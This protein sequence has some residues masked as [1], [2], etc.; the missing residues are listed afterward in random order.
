MKI[1]A[2]DLAPHFERCREV[3]DARNAGILGDRQAESLGISMNREGNVR[4][5]WQDINESDIYIFKAFLDFYTDT[6]NAVDNPKPTNYV[7][8]PI[9]GDAT[10]NKIV[11][12]GT[13]RNAFTIVRPMADDKYMLIQE[14]RLGY[15]ES[16]VSGTDV[17]YDEAR[18]ETEDQFHGDSNSYDGRKFVTVVWKGVSPDKSHSISESIDNLSPDLDDFTVNGNS[19][20]GYRRVMVR[21]QEE[22]DGSHSIRMMVAQ[23]RLTYDMY[24]NY[25]TENQGAVVVHFGVPSDLVQAILDG[26][27]SIGKSARVSPPDNMG[28]HTI[29]VTTSSP[30]KNV[31][32]NVLIS[33][34]CSQEVY[35]SAYYGLTLAEADSVTI[36]ANENGVTYRL[37]R[38]PRGDGFWT[39]I[40]ETITTKYQDTTLYTS[41]DS[42]GRLVKRRSQLGVTNEEVEEIAQATGWTKQQTI[43]LNDDCSKDVDTVKVQAIQQV[44]SDDK[45]TTKYSVDG[46][47]TLNSDSAV[48][49]A[50]PDQGVTRSVRNTPNPDGTYNVVEVDE[51][52]PVLASEET[53]STVKQT[54][55][56][57]GTRNKRGTQP[58]AP[59][60]A[61]GER[62]RHRVSE[63]PDG[64]WDENT[65]IEEA[66]SGLEAGGASKSK[67]NDF[68]EDQSYRNIT[69]E[70]LAIYL[71]DA[72]A[73]V[74][75]TEGKRLVWQKRE[76]EDGLWDFSYRI[77]TAP[78]LESTSNVIRAK[79]GITETIKRNIVTAAKTPTPDFEIGKTKTIRH[80]KNA[81]CSWDESLRVETAPDLT[82]ESSV[83]QKDVEI[84]VTRRQNQPTQEP[85]PTV[86][87]ND[88]YRLVNDENPDGSWNTSLEV[89]KPLSQLAAF[90]CLTDGGTIGVSVFKNYT[91]DQVTSL[92]GG[93]DGTTNNSPSVQ[94]NKYGLYDGSLTK[95]P[96]RK[97]SGANGE[98]KWADYSYSLKVSGTTYTVSVIYT[99]DP[100]EAASHVQGDDPQGLVLDLELPRAVGEVPGIKYVGR[101]S[102]KAVRITTS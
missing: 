46:T 96:I 39:V 23:S 100:V 90:S 43:R 16:L 31:D 34:N 28:L 37:R 19:L 58:V 59:T 5:V 52:S 48:A 92:F 40:L 66:V 17:D 72:E 80:D 14:L 79:G 101:K 6:V 99:T 82:S 35:Q 84:T 64:T 9:V 10:N 26:S 24:E 11:A 2:L 41:E 21:A 45:G 78:V 1:T 29:T 73:E 44:G 4:R 61:V 88:I 7:K 25:G 98:T 85:I 22:S 91:S 76:L 20:S 18:V 86:D 8:D 30:D 97:N 62:V 54:V 13:Y 70:Q 38:Q 33:R 60:P 15:I 102:Y 3:L 63:N 89:E 75:A 83:V 53:V 32:L 55:T 94:P 50:T 42:A 27:Q 65:I 95:A 77:E 69:A 56:G 67:C 36:P 12:P 81:D 87:A 51:V 71:A 74:N 57:T 47:I 49:Y 68:G 93:A